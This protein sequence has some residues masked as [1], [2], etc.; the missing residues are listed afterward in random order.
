[1][2]LRDDIFAKFAP[3]PQKVEGMNGLPVYARSLSG[4]DLFDL[5]AAEATAD[6]Y[7]LTVLRGACDEKG[8]RIFSDDD[9]EKVRSLP[10]D[11]CGP[12]SD[13]VLKLSGLAGDAEGKE[14]SLPTGASPSG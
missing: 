13:L 12:V 11:F 5:N 1:M 6:K 4:A 14:V 7:L 10:R 2:S 3:T 8:E 9:R